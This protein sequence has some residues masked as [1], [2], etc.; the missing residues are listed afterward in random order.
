MSRQG[1]LH[2]S[3]FHVE[4]A[5]YK[6]AVEHESDYNITYDSIKCDELHAR[7][8][9][10]LLWNSG[11]IR[12]SYY[13]C[14]Y[15]NVKNQTCSNCSECAFFYMKRCF[16]PKCPVKNSLRKNEAPY[17]CYYLS[18]NKDRKKYLAISNYCQRIYLTKLIEE[19]EK[20]IR[21]KRSFIQQA[22]RE[23]RSKNT[24]IKDKNYLINKIHTKSNEIIEAEILLKKYLSQLSA[25]GGR[26]TS[27]PH[28]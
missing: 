12:C 22:E 23:L 14:K 3:P 5:Q 21:S 27:F 20:K 11:F 1:K 9:Y 10:C 13:K 16:H 24:A 4:S 2:S 25:I 26:L 17:C 19:Y 28:K 7:T 15:F 6:Y 8:Q 18:A